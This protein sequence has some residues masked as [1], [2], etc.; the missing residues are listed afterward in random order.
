MCRFAAPLAFNF[1][2]AIALPQAKGQHDAPVRGPA[3]HFVVGCACG[4]VMGA[5][6]AAEQMRWLAFAAAC[7]CCRPPP[8][9]PI[10][11]CPHHPVQDVT[12]TV[13]YEQLG[14][15]MMRQQLIGWQVGGARQGAQEGCARLAQ[16]PCFAACCG[17]ACQLALPQPSDHGCCIDNQHP[18]H[19]PQFTTFAPVL[20]VPWML[21]LSWCAGVLAG[22]LAGALGRQRLICCT[23]AGMSLGRSCCMLAAHFCTTSWPPPPLAF[24]SQRRVWARH[25]PGA[26]RRRPRLRGRLAGGLMGMG[27]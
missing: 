6:V 15:L 2:A 5:A 1:M 19:P 23:L 25:Q 14:R 22:A 20:L 8:S 9:S 26:A 3:L 7:L 21:L 27:C 11:L 10:A 12:D 13:F 24:A 4:R 18:T 17:P 16:L